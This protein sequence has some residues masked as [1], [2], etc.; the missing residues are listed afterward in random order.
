M[1]I[2][3]ADLFKYKTLLQLLHFCGQISI[4]FLTIVV[5]NSWNSKP[6]NIKCQEIVL[7]VKFQPLL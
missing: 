7:K 1:Y 5:I 4:T 6:S 2:P 3:K